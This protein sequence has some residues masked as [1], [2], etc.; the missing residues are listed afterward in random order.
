MAEATH[1][2]RPVITKANRC[3]YHMFFDRDFIETR[4]QEDKESGSKQITTLF[5]SLFSTAKLWYLSKMCI[6]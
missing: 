6:E 4:Q 1:A 2:D 3:A 5:R